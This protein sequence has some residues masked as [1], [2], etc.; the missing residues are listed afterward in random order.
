MSPPPSICQAIEDANSGGNMHAKQQQA[1]PVASQMQPQ[2]RFM[3]KIK[4]SSA[5]L[6]IAVFDQ[7]KLCE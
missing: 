6:L 2:V 4:Y 1:H 3:M 5:R 7:Q